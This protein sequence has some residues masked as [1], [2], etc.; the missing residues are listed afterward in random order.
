MTVFQ[1]GKWIDPATGSPYAAG[2]FSLGEGARFD[3][4]VHTDDELWLIRSGAATIA[5]DGVETLVTAGDIVRIPAGTV[6]DI[7]AVHPDVAGFFVETGHPGAPSGHLHPDPA[8]AAGHDVP[9][10]PLPGKD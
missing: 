10:T 1:P 9:V 3:R 5:L 8:D 7:L 2:R 6:H 4:H